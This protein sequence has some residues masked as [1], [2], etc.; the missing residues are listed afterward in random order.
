M[1][2]QLWLFNDAHWGASYS[3][4]RVAPSA[5]VVSGSDDFMEL[6]ISSVL[7]MSPEAALMLES[8]GNA[9]PQYRVRLENP[10]LKRRD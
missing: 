8:I 3:D 7:A 5:R 10:H 2:P 1:A 9:G 6:I 4:G